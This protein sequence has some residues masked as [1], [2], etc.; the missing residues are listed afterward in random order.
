MQYEEDPLIATEILSSSERQRTETH[1][2]S[3]SLETLKLEQSL[4]GPTINIT[5]SQDKLSAG[6]SS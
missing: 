5:K 4:K 2:K 3:E 1:K 6:N